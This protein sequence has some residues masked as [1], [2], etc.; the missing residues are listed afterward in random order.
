MSYDNWKTTD[1][2]EKYYK[3]CPGNN[4]GEE[5]DTRDCH[6][7]CPYCGTHLN[8]EPDPDA[9]YDAWRDRQMEKDF[10]L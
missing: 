5:L 3:R 2:S 9:L 6:E 1:P 8:S 4:C 10:D 7:V